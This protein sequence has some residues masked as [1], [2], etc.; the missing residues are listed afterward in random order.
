MLARIVCVAPALR[1]AT[2]PQG[3]HRN[4]MLV[5]NARGDLEAGR[6]FQY[7]LA[8][9]GDEVKSTHLRFR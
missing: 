8:L 7:H 3:G 1:A 6:T 4:P 9:I 2:P 5:I